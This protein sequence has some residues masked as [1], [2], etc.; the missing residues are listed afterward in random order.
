[1]QT[2]TQEASHTNGD[3]TP[4]SLQETPESAT[5][6]GENDSKKKKVAKERTLKTPVDWEIPRK[7]L[8]T[9]IGAFVFH[10]MSPPLLL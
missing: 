6:E 1:M 8:H 3:G 4:H 5:S 2:H 9:S 7:S 10:Y